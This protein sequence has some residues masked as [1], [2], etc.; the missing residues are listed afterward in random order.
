MGDGKSRP[1]FLW[2]FVAAVLRILN[3][4]GSHRE[5]AMVIVEQTMTLACYTVLAASAALVIA[6]VC[7]ATSPHSVVANEALPGA[8]VLAAALTLTSLIMIDI[9]SY[10]PRIFAACS[11]RP[12]LFFHEL[13]RLSPTL[14]NQVEEV[15]GAKP[16]TWK[17]V[18]ELAHLLLAESH[19]F[20]LVDKLRL[21]ITLRLM[22]RLVSL[23]LSLA[24]IGYGLEAVTHSPL[25][26]PTNSVMADAGLTEYAYFAVITFFTIGFGDVHPSHHPA[27]YAYLAVIILCFITVFYFV[28][29]EIVSSHGEFRVNIKTAAESFV[30]ERSRDL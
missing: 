10:K 29:S 15:K 9:S 22:T 11:G 20:L 27:G 23:L 5:H 6:D 17:Q 1:A 18:K 19:Q 30:V 14:R 12:E 21:Q 7:N 3:P 24:L 26:A 8:F 2:R 4:K 28:L 16:H 13:A 25:L